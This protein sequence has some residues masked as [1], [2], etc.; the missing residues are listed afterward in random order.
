MNESNGGPTA[1]ALAKPSQSFLRTLPRNLAIAAVAFGILAGIRWPGIWS[2]THVL[3]D[4]S[5]GFIKRGLFGELLS[6]FGGE[7][8]RYA[9]I[10][11]VCFAVF[12]VWLAVL[13]S[14]LRS[15]G[16]DDWW[17]WVFAAVFFVSPGFVFM[18]HEVGY[19][20]HVGLAV[21]LLC[22]WLPFST[23]GL[24]ARVFLC[25]SMTFVHE[26]FFLMFFGAVVVQYLLGAA[27]R[28]E[29]HVSARAGVLVLVVAASTFFV[30]QTQLPEDDWDDYVAHL[31]SRSADFD[32]YEGTARVLFRDAEDNLKFM[33][34]IRSRPAYWSNA[35]LAIVFLLPF[36]LLLIAVARGMLRRWGELSGHGRTILAVIV[37]ASLSPLLLNVLAQDLWRFFA[38]AQVSAFLVLIAVIRELRLAV[39]P[40]AWARP[41]A[42]ALGALAVVGGATATPLFSGRE[43]VRPPYEEHI[44][45]LN[46]V[47]TGVT[48]FPAIP[49]P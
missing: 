27:V 36:P 42:L 29:P 11:V 6:M 3:F 47:T 5:H 16:R 10:A 21:A 40:P 38:L 41:A 35:L 17:V 37:G 15:V 26:A 23:G 22:F 4:Y 18:V 25:V 24:I 34:R 13:W 33:S 46:E 32:P 44:E 2:A 8:I 45:Y 9:T 14:H 48:D 12:G 1:E 31:Q 30:G 20:D 49:E 43:V 19:M 7:Q 28:H 39:V